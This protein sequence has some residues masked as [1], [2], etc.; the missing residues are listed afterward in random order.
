MALKHLLILIPGFPK[1]ED[2]NTCLPPVQQFLLCYRR[3][4]PEVKIS[5]I[6]LHYPYHN[7]PYQWDGIDVCPIN[8]RNG[9]GLKRGL[10]IS[11]AVNEA[12]KVNKLNKVDLVF[13]FWLT[14]A[15]LAGKL[16][17]RFLRTPHF[18]WMQGQDAR[19]GNKYVRL[20]RP[21][22]KKLA[23]LS[24]YHNEVLYK[25]Y[26]L[27]ADHVI[28]NGINKEIFPL[29]NEKQRGIDLFAAGSLIPLKQYHLFL[30]LVKHVKE[31]GYANIRAELAGD[32]V[33]RNNLAA[34]IKENELEE[35]V[36]LLGS[37]PHKEV[38]DKM[39][40]AKLFIHTSSYESQSTVVLEALYSGCSTLSFLPV[41]NKEIENF[42]FCKDFDE[43]MVNALELLSTQLVHTRVKCYDMEESAIK[44]HSILEAMLG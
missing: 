32:G 3:K 22:V 40:D 29:F 41:S 28:D 21:D 19:E 14:D 35:N 2:D 43:M 34:F 7:S 23:A 12:R 26:E 1:D 25:N 24:E 42:F 4:F 38:L 30:D 6:S 18:I 33:L 31:N 37:I 44:A 11:Q 27:K 17:A 5:V 9:S 36:K 10:I 16:I 15:A 13:S 39:N 8:G 20:V